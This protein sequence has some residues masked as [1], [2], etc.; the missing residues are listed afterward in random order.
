MCNW[1]PT[2]QNLS[3][4]VG[5]ERRGCALD[6]H[7]CELFSCDGDVMLSMSDFRKCR[8]HSNCYYYISITTF[9]QAEQLYTFHD[10]RNMH[11]SMHMLFAFFL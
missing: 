4:L 11:E 2:G 9:P 7:E 3:L 6:H 10:T 5:C 8:H 1:L